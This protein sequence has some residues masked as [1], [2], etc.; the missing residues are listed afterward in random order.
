MA[1]GKIPETL[2]VAVL[3][4][5]S[6]LLFLQEHARNDLQDAVFINKDEAVVLLQATTLQ[7]LL[8]CARP[9]DERIDHVLRR[10]AL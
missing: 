2:L 4:Q 6:T 5:R 10:V 3:I 7:K 1:T 8:S 9:G